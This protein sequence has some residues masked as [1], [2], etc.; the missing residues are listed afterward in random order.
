MIVNRNVIVDRSEQNGFINSGIKEF[1][2]F[3]IAMDSPGADAKSMIEVKPA[4]G[5]V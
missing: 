2:I 4:T 5:R 1:S 3:A